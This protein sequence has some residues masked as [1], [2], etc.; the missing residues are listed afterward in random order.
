M[1]T[2]RSLLLTPLPV[3]SNLVGQWVPVPHVEE[4]EQGG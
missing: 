2:T 4:V 3:W 1:T